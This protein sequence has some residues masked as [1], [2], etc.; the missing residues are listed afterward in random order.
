MVQQFI[1]RGIKLRIPIEEYILLFAS[2]YCLELLIYGILLF[3]L[4]SKKQILALCLF[5]NVITHPLV[6]YGFP[7]WFSK[8]EWILAELFAWI[9][10]ALLLLVISRWVVY[11]K[12]SWTKAFSTSLAANALSAGVVL[13][14]YAAL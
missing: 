1:F 3:Q 14:F 4:F 13:L 12:M 5:L 9:V 2:T 8:Y 11:K 7:R 10:E 6:C